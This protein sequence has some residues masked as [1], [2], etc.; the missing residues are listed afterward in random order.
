MFSILQATPSRPV[1]PDLLLLSFCEHS[2]IPQ[3]GNCRR[4][5]SRPYIDLGI[6]GR[7]SYAVYNNAG[8]RYRYYTA[9][10]VI[11]CV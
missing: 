5:L 1:L 3:A 9:Y 11:C 6:I 10:S 8:C 7:L 2:V 4:Q